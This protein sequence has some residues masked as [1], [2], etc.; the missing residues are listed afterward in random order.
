MPYVDDAALLAH[1]VLF[2]R[3]YAFRAS[4]LIICCLRYFRRYAM[5]FRYAATL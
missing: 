4:M 1:A 5:L 2:F 3:A